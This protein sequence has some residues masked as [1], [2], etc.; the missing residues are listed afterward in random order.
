MVEDDLLSNLHVGDALRVLL[1]RMVM[2]MLLFFSWKCIG[3][4]AVLWYH[5]VVALTDEW[6]HLKHVLRIGA[7]YC[8][9]C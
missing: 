5:N 6:S 1:L 4:D 8:C 3:A 7:A 9:R 2:L